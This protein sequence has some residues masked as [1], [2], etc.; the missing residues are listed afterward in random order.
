M[1]YQ[2]AEASLFCITSDS[3]ISPAYSSKEFV[4]CSSSMS[5]HVSTDDISQALQADA[6]APLWNTVVPEQGKESRSAL[7]RFLQPLHSYFIV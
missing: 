3:V 1:L 2:T 4:S 7:H 6:K 5:K